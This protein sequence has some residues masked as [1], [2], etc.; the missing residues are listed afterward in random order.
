[1]VEL[2]PL[3]TPGG[4]AD[5]AQRKAVLPAAAGLEVF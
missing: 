2:A 1:M 3:H 4:C 5:S